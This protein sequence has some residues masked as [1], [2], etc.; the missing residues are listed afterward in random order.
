MAAEP[1]SSQAPPGWYDDPEVEGGT[2]YWD[3]ERWTEQRQGPAKPTADAPPA[4]WYDDPE[5]E[6]GWRYWDGGT[7]TN[8][9]M[10]AD[11]KQAAKLV[12]NATSF[13]PPDSPP[14]K[15]LPDTF[16]G[17][18]DPS[19]LV[20]ALTLTDRGLRRLMRALNEGQ[21]QDS[22]EFQIEVRRV[23]R[24]LRANREL[25]AGSGGE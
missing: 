10:D 25:R 3:G 8:E 21:D 9:R 23:K 15:Q 24:Q 20:E 13:K 5:V 16:P 17:G 18:I 14:A 7:W 1:K 11:P 19:R 22:E 12:N 6:G 4:G 2:R